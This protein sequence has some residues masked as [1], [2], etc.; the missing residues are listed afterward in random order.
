MAGQHRC[1]AV[2]GRFWNGCSL[3]VVNGFQTDVVGHDVGFFK[4]CLIRSIAQRVTCDGILI[5]IIDVFRDDATNLVVTLAIHTARRRT[6]GRT[7][8][9]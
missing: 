7:I 9:V 4:D 5:D 8:V 2:I 6:E 3:I 1:M